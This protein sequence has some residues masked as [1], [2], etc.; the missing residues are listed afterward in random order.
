MLQLLLGEASSTTIQR[1]KAMTL[2]TE[3]IDQTIAFIN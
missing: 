3:G 2:A 1:P